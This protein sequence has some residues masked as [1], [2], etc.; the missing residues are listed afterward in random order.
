MRE[1]KQR[2]VITFYTTAEAIATKKLCQE[3]MIKGKLISAPRSLSADCGIA[4]CSDIE[5]SDILEKSL[6]DAEIEYAGL[7]KMLI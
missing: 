4:W 3:K 1:K 6:A 2:I 5:Y 7:F